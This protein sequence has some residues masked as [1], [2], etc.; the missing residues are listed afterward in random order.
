MIIKAI[1]W[2]VCILEIAVCAADT[3]DYDS[4]W[5]EKEMLT[6]EELDELANDLWEQES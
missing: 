6:Q 4:A 2:A 1:L 3:M 5:E